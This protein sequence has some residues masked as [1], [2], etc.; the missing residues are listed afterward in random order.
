MAAQAV[1]RS[2]SGSGAFYR[3]IRAKRGAPKAI[4]ATAHRIARIVYHMLKHQE[5][6][7]DQGSVYYEEQHRQ[8][9]VKNLK[10]KA[11]KLGMKVV[12]VEV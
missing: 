6:Y 3:R 9:A 4:V 8:R 1:A 11:A 2:D 12:P 10:R 7:V 5:A